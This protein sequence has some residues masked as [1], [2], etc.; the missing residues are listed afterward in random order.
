MLIVGVRPVA[1]AALL[2]LA[3]TLLGPVAY[4]ARPLRRIKVEESQFKLTLKR[5][6][7]RWVRW[8]EAYEVKLV[9]HVGGLRPLLQIGDKEQLLANGKLRLG[10]GLVV[11]V[12]VHSDRSLT[13]RVGDL[14]LNLGPTR[15]YAF[16]NMYLGPRPGLDAAGAARAFIARRFFLGETA[17]RE[18]GRE[19]DA[20]TKPK[21][22]EEGWLRWSHPF[23]D[24]IAW[25]DAEAGRIDVKPL[26]WWRWQGQIARLVPQGKT[27]FDSVSGP[28]KWLGWLRPRT[29][30]VLEWKPITAD[31]D[32]QF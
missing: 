26:G 31:D 9:F 32:T 11:D 12:K 23:H 16:G 3:S 15:S 29:R 1:V 4:A 13:V 25:Q 28:Q 27:V 24:R 20:G 30:A 10:G 2:A 6:Y 22:V 18:L 5:S 19:L 21:E 8:R 14:K 17:A 7:P